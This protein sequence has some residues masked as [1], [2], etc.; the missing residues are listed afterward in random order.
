[1]PGQYYGGVVFM[2][3]LIYQILGITKDAHISHTAK[4]CLTTATDFQATLTICVFSQIFG[5]FYFIF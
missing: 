5:R 3:T 1:M 4:H 2:L